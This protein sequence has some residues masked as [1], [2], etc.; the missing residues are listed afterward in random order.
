MPRVRVRYPN[1]FKF[2]GMF[3]AS[4][5]E[6]TV[7]DDMFT[8]GMLTMVDIIDISGTVVSPDVFFGTAL[9]GEDEL[10]D[11]L[12]EV[13]SKKGKKK[14]KKVVKEEVKGEGVGGEDVGGEDEGG[15]D[16]GG[17]DEGGEDV[18]GEN[19]GGEEVVKKSKKGKKKSKKGSL[20]KDKE[21]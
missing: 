4:L 1:R 3:H 5:D 13:K 9:L 18:G 20:K 6:L 7:P 11:E 15:E 10:F 19:E 2:Q 16:V 21:A 17:E 14:S 8:R 12:P